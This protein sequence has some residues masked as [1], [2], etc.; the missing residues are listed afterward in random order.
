MAEVFNIVNHKVISH[1]SNVAFAHY[2]EPKLTTKAE[3][4][5]ANFFLPVYAQLGVGSTIVCSV[6]N[7]VVIVA[8][9]ASTVT[10]V[11]VAQIAAT[12]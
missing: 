12:A 8:V 2:I 9:T 7:G 3:V 4:L 1:V 5:A 6:S 10:G 11:T